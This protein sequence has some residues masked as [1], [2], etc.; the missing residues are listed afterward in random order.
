MYKNASAQPQREV[1][2]NTFKL[3]LPKQNAD[4]GGDE[5]EETAASVLTPQ[6]KVILAYI[7]KTGYIT[8]GIIGEMF[9]I[10]STRIY[11]LI[12]QMERMGMI[13]IEGRGK[14]KRYV[15]NTDSR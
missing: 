5:N 10:Q 11:N 6:M 13:Q 14:G 8:D 15:A 12:K 1:T 7:E 9:H 2:S 3:V 4:E